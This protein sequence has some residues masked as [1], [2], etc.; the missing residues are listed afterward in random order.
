MRRIFFRNIDVATSF[1]RKRTISENA[2]TRDYLQDGVDRQ[3]T[4]EGASENMEAIRTP[5]QVMLG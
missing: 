1:K 5:L 4:I 2:S 3:Q